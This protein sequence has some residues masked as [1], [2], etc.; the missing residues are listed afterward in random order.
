MTEASSAADWAA[1][2]AASR[3]GDHA[4][5]RAALHRILARDRRDL[6]ALLAMGETHVKS[7]DSRAA[8][9]WFRT[10]LNQASVTPPPP[11]LHPLL[12]RAQH[13]CIDAQA[14]FAEQFEAALGEANIA[15]SASPALKHALDLLYGRS[16]IHLQQPTM[17]YYP[18]LP[19][20]AFYER[21]EFAWVA[22]IEAQAATMRDEFLAAL[23]IDEPFAPYI[24][25]SD[26]RPASSSPLLD[27]AN[28][29]AAYLWQ[30]GEH[31]PL[32]AHC[33]ATMAALTAAPIPHIAARSPMALY[34]R[35]KPGTHIAPHHGL[36]NTRLICH[37]PLVVPEGCAMRVGH[38]TRAW[39]FGELTIFDDS[40]EHEAWNRGTSD[41]TVL[42]FEIWRP[43]IPVEER[44]ALARLF[45]TI[46]R[47]DPE[48][49]KEQA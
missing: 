34:S 39:R 43:E 42:L 37:L 6:P 4:A 20:R 29:G 30:S 49:G 3:S 17:F 22:D 38:E 11:A 24:Q 40:F 45:E 26:S 44:E 14:A 10:A 46:D 23:A 8:A 36:L 41:R 16:E 13:Y 33:P 48:R 1:A 7:G 19:Q 25:R 12:S 32:A 9:S 5:E 27:S 35:L 18:G 2:R 28:W 31:T 21:H 15:A 47:V